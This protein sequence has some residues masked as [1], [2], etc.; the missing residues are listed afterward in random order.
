MKAQKRLRPL[1][2]GGRRPPGLRV[3]GAKRGRPDVGRHGVRYLSQGLS[4]ERDLDGDRVARLTHRREAGGDPLE[5]RR[6]LRIPVPGPRP[7]QVGLQGRG[8][9]DSFVHCFRSA[10]S[11]P[12]YPVRATRPPTP[13]RGRLGRRLQRRIIW[14]AE[15]QRSPETEQPNESEVVRGRVAATNGD[16]PGNAFDGRP[17]RLR[18]TA[19]RAKPAGRRLR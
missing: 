19:T 9:C 7:W 4:G 17:A 12:L 13:E 16:P 8:C 2:E 6:I 3:S 18:Y 1:V 15:L 14:K 10:L 5:H 11:R